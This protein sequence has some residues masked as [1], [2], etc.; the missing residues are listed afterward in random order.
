MLLPKL[1][2]LIFSHL[3]YFYGCFFIANNIFHNLFLHGWLLLG[4]SYEKETVISKGL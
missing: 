4:F 2:V 3:I 1:Y